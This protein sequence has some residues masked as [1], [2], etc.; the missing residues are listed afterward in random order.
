MAKELSKS[1]A[2]AAKCLFAAL[3]YLKKKGDGAPVREISQYIE[4]NVKLTDWEK[5]R[6][7]KYNSVRWSTNYQFYSID[8]TKAGYIVKRNRMWYITPEGEDAL[9]LSPNEVLLN[10][11]AAYQKWLELNQKIEPTQTSDDIEEDEKRENILQ[12][13]ELEVKAT[14]GIQE[15]IKNK[16][17]YAFQDMV[18]ALLRAMGY[19][20]PFIAPKGKDGGVDIIAYIDPLGATTPR[21]KVQV[22]HMPET[23]IGSKDIQALVGALKNG[24]IG[25]FVTSGTFSRDA[26][27]ASANSKEY[28]R[29]IDGEEFIDMWNE[30]YDKMTDE[31]KNML[32]LKRIAFLGNNE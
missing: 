6:S 10:A 3:Q 21:I 19:H 27:N 13:D 20:T 4:D 2:C 8:F 28:I 17:P 32:P 30:Y 16:N 29:I 15:Y 26:K 1:A 12:L 9:K 11:S 5:E 7:G 18:A 22:K 25:L 23:A 14:T 31:D 24:D